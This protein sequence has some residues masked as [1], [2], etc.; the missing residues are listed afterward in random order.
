MR[1][2]RIKERNYIKFDLQIYRFKQVLK[3]NCKGS[4]RVAGDLC[5]PL[6]PWSE[7]DVS[8]FRFPVWKAGL[9]EKKIIYI[10]ILSLVFKIFNSSFQSLL[11]FRCFS[12][13]LT[14]Y[15]IHLQPLL[16][17]YDVLNV[18]TLH[19][20]LLSFNMHL[21]KTMII[22]EINKKKICSIYMQSKAVNDKIKKNFK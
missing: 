5:R 12:W 6:P 3:N 18:Y 22:K 19:Y 20:G 13:I 7:H 14:F 2:R 10:L 21:I 9:K 15:R 4:T 8:A 1:T 11:L 17:V 16:R